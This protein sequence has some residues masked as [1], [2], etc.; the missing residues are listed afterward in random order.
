MGKVQRLPIV[1][2]VCQVSRIRRWNRVAMHGEA[3]KVNTPARG[4]AAAM[5]RQWQ[6]WIKC[7]A[8]RKMNETDAMEK[9]STPEQDMAEMRRLW[10]AQKQNPIPSARNVEH[11]HQLQKKAFREACKKAINRP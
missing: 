11:W 2:A 1:P 6:A 5:T 9:Q 4:N 3:G 7:R 10:A 8:A